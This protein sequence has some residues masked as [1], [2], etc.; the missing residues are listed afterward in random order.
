MYTIQKLHITLFSLLLLCFPLQG[1]EKKTEVIPGIEVLFTPEYQSLLRGKNIGLV[2]NHTG[3]TRSFQS[4]VSLMKQESGK[5]GY[6]IVALFAP[7]HGI[8]GASHAA[9]KIEDIHKAGEIPIFSL[10]GKTQRPTLEMLKGIDLLIYD[11]QDIGARCYTYSTTLYYL[12]E[13]AAKQK[14]PVIVTDRP[15]PINGVVVDGPMM[16]E[17]WRSIVGY[18]NVP[19]CHGMTIG[20]LA[21]YFNEEYEINCDLTVIPMKG[22]KR[23]MTFSDTGLPWIP[24]SPNIPESSTA[25]YYPSTGI[26]GELQIINIGIGYTLP[27]KIIGAPWIH[28]EH[29][30]KKLNEQKLP[31]VIFLPFYYKPFYGNFAQMNCEGVLISVTD[32]ESFKPVTTQYVILGLLKSLYP[33]EFHKA[34]DGAKSREDM[35]AKVNGTDEIFHILKKKPYAAWELRSFHEKERS[36]FLE[37][38]KEYLLRNYL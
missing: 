12:M 35:F 33:K 32:H 19:Y 25:L 6:K 38:R 15:N 14:I 24:T 34:L 18:I 1:K 27:F 2:T 5:I 13:E 36:A 4:T 16:E 11:I 30:A 21:R 8:R 26:A 29:F 23:K 31:G 28:A 20:E 17:K 10:Y 22:W 3:V 9:E 37:K 7:E